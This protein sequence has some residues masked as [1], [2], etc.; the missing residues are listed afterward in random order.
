MSAA[1]YI[2]GTLMACGGVRVEH[3]TDCY[4]LT[5]GAAEWTKLDKSLMAA[6]PRASGVVLSDGSWI[7]CGGMDANYLPIASCERYTVGGGNF[8]SMPSL[9]LPN[10]T[11]SPVLFLIDPDTLFFVPD[12]ST[13][14]YTIDITS[15]TATAV[16]AAMSE[17]RQSALGGLVAFPDRSK[18]AVVAGGYDSNS[19]EMYDLSSGQWSTGPGLPLDSL[20]SGAG[21]SVP[22]GDTFLIAGANSDRVLKFN[23]AGTWDTLATLSRPVT[24]SAAVLLP[25]T[26]DTCVMVP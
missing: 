11:I 22:Y 6:R 23:P 21:S 15:G 13:Q 5:A 7:I 16:A 3:T 10:A 8:A 14:A 26:F 24:Y 4:G 19:C 17:K 2:N 1:A 12:D 18:K 25:D 20:Y 9:S